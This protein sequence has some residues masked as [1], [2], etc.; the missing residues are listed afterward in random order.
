MLKSPTGDALDPLEIRPAE[1]AAALIKFCS[2]QK[3]PLPRKAAKSI[4]VDN[5]QVSLVLTLG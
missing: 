5:G 2:L 4:A 3:I 1:V